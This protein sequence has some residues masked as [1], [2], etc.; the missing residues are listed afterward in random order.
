MSKRAKRLR[1]IGKVWAIVEG[2]LVVEG[3]F[4]PKLGDFVY[5]SGME[6]VGVVSGIFGPVNHFF[7]EINPTKKTECRKDEPLYVLESEHE[8]KKKTI[9]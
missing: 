2:K 7:I 8:A 4:L 6:V 3:E 5:N 9:R 1:K